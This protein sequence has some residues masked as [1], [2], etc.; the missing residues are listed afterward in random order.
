MTRYA[1][2]ILLITVV[3]LSITAIATNTGT[4]RLVAAI[5]GLVTT[6]GAVYLV[7]NPT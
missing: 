2:Q 5:V 7:R 1:R 3:A 4:A 6:A